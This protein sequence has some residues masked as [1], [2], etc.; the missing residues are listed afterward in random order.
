MALGDR[1]AQFLVVMVMVAIT[2]TYVVW[3]DQTASSRKS[4]VR[5]RVL[6]RPNAFMSSYAHTFVP[7]ELSG[8]LV[9]ALL[10]DPGVSVLYQAWVSLMLTFLNPSLEHFCP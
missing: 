7:I 5:G 8:L 2:S 1:Q 10:L 4:E 3:V 6:C 9:G